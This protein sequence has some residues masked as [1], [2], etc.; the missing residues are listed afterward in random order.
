MLYRL[1]EEYES[2]LQKIPG[3]EGLT[4]E[5][6]ALNRLRTSAKSVKNEINE[7]YVKYLTGKL[8]QFLGEEKNAEVRIEAKG[9]CYLVSAGVPGALEGFTR[10]NRMTG[11]MVAARLK[12]L[13]GMDAVERRNPQKGAFTL[14]RSSVNYK[15]VLS[16]EPNDYGENLVLSQAV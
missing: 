16:T 14:I 7:P 8:L 6:A 3:S 9:A 13:G 15:L 10:F 1:T 4:I 12:A 11:N 5:E 2:A